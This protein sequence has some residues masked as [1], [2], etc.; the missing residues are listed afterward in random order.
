MNRVEL[1]LDLVIRQS[2]NGTVVIA[3]V[4]YG[5]GFEGSL[6]HLPSEAKLALYPPHLTRA[7][8][9]YAKKDESKLFVL[10]H[11]FAWFIIHIY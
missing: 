2:R 6:F 1:R 7:R 10:P 11:Y 9:A 4:V 3:N 8:R 5:F